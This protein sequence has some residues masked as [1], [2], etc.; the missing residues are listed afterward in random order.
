[1]NESLTKS[2]ETQRRLSA[3]L[4]NQ[5]GAIAIVV[6][7]LFP[8]LLGLGALA[9]D[10]GHI[11]LVKAQLQNAA[12]A[13][14]LAGGM[15]LLPFTGT[16]PQP[17]WPQAQAQATLY[18][19]K[20][21]ADGQPLS[22]CQS[23][24]LYWNFVTNS[25]RP[26]QQNANDAPVIQVTVTK[27]ETSGNGPVQLMFAPIWGIF[28]SDVSA[29]ARAMLSGASSVPTAS[30]FPLAINQSVVNKYWDKQPPVTI[31]IGSG[32]LGG[33]WTSFLINANDVP[34]IRGLL[35]KG[36]PSPL[37]VGDSIYIQPGKKASLYG[38]AAEK[39]GRTVLLAVVGDDY[40]SKT[41]TPILG[42]AAFLIKGTDQGGKTISGYFT[43]YQSPQSS[44]GGPAYGV[45][46][47]AK[48]IN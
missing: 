27:S 40:Q 7:L 37:Q 13:G 12:D 41:Y 47:P 44:P 15:G 25:L 10:I 2:S 18:V 1:M 45:F 3:F 11:V 24:L 5:E 36:N 48:L 21:S 9:V 39:I 35:D 31:N 20:N 14:A 32:G 34:T 42:F 28:T 8:V 30:A 38:Y 46:V 22:A 17:N 23:Q 33:Q 26:T 4:V 16:P 19:T 6:A 29:T 43:P